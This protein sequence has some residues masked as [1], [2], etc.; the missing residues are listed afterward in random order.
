MKRLN[1][2]P[3]IVLVGLLSLSSVVALSACSNTAPQDNAS[4]QPTTEAPEV[5][6]SPVDETAAGTASPDTASPSAAGSE[7]IVE[8]ASTNGSFKTLT[9]A[10][11]AAGLTET[12]SGKGPY[13]VFAPSDEA[14]AAL[15]EGAVEELLKPENKDKLVQLLS[16]HVVPGEVSSSQ[17]TPGEVKTVE[18][19]P[20]TV[21]V[22]KSTSEVKVNNAKVTQPDIEA[23]NGVIHAIDKVI[24]P[25]DA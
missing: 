25:P 8:L 2:I 15:P 9:K 13:T 4:E 24:L 14:F 3:K 10:I 17:I 7:N 23:S 16:Y 21:E 18:G 12:L 11:E 19:A 1:G 5:A 6:S 22:D 20:I